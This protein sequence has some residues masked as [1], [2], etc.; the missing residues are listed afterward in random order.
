MRSLGWVWIVGVLG[1]L[2]VVVSLA[3]LASADAVAVIFDS[4]LSVLELDV[5]SSWCRLLALSQAL[6]L[7]AMA[8]AKHFCTSGHCILKCFVLVFQFT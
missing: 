5:C 4:H 8:S 1:L 7:E 6:W 2:G 3:P